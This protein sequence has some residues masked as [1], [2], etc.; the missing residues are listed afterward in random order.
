MAV[1]EDDDAESHVLGFS[2]NL[3]DKD[4]RNLDEE[5]T[6]AKEAGQGPRSERDIQSIVITSPVDQNRRDVDSKET[7]CISDDSI[8][9]SHRRHLYRHDRE[10]RSGYL[11]DGSI[12][13]GQL[14]HHNKFMTEKE[15]DKL[16]WEACLAS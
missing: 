15:K 11:S 14:G 10:E 3:H 1:H 4:D 7:P 12:S 16:F 6:A 2:Y 5:I 9:S 8:S 13:K